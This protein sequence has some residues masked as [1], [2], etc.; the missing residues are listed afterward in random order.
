M[1]NQ[2]ISAQ[3]ELLDHTW[4][5][6]RVGA[7][8]S[9]FDVASL[10][11]SLPNNMDAQ[12]LTTETS[13][14]S[15]R[16]SPR[17]IASALNGTSLE[18]ENTAPILKKRRLEEDDR[19]HLC[20]HIHVEDLCVATVVFCFASWGVGSQKNTI[21]GFRYCLA[22]GSERSYQL[23]F[24]WIEKMTGNAIP[25]FPARLSQ[26]Q[27]IRMAVQGIIE[28]QYN[29]AEIRRNKRTA[30]EFTFEP[31]VSIRDKGFDAVSCS[32][33]MTTMFDLCEN[34]LGIDGRLPVALSH[35][36]NVNTILQAIRSL[37]DTTM[38][39]SIDSFLLR[40]VTWGAAAITSSGQFKPKGGDNLS[41]SLD[42]IGEW[43]SQTDD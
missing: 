38:K 37:I 13:H 41:W 27:L 43:L 29:D 6:H 12:F 22:R 39:V 10:E 23:A 19:Q 5:I 17:R 33:P 40:Q 18:N 1:M 2:T 4:C 3:R 28:Q 24:Q 9:T 14:D 11:T 20:I 16:R 21:K 42:E 7:F 36:Q 15:G 26:T 32:F 8:A 35:Q 31:S 30:V 34:Q 25:R